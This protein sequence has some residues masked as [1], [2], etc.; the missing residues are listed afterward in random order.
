MKLFNGLF[1]DFTL[2]AIGVNL[3]LIGG[4]LMMDRMDL[5]WLGGMSLL[6]CGVGLTISD[7]LKANEDDER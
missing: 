4:A 7:M 3:T 5:A 2:I 6:L 1:R